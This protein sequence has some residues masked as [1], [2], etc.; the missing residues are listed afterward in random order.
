MFYVWWMTIK[1]LVSLKTISP[2]D[3]VHAGQS[4]SWSVHI[5]R[6]HQGRNPETAWTETERSAACFHSCSDECR[7]EE[8]VILKCFLPSFPVC[9]P[10]V[11]WYTHFPSAPTDGGRGGCKY[12]TTIPVFIFSS[13]IFSWERME[14]LLSSGSWMAW[15][16][17]TITLLESYPSPSLHWS[18]PSTHTYFYYELSHHLWLR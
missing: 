13:L 18:P 3:H 1:L 15:I 4:G 16:E 8:S 11:K 5:Q 12:S 6:I 2:T 9:G 17:M 14:P 7:V 10:V